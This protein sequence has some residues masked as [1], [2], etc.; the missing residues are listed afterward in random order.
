MKE[1]TNTLYA[2]YKNGIHL[3][4]E[5]GININDAIRK[6]LIASLYEDFLEDKEFASLYSGKESIKKIHFL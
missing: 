2:I 5:K 6:Y 4:N 3:G 1:E